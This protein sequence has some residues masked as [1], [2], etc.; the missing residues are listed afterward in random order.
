MTKLRFGIAI[1][2]AAVWVISNGL[3]VIIKTY[4]PP[5]SIHITMMAIVGWVVGE[6]WKAKDKNEEVEEVEK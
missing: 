5:A 2:V 3:D 1:V 4:D 6:S